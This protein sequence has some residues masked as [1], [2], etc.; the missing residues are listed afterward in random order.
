M[1]KLYRSKPHIPQQDKK[2][3]LSEWKDILDTG[4]FAQG[5]NVENFEKLVAEYCNVKHA[6]ATSSGGTAVEVALMATGIKNK[7]FIVCTQTFVVSISAIIR[8]GN[9]PV[10]VDMDEKS[11]GLSANIIAKHIDS[12]TAGVMLV[13]MAGHITSDY[14]EIQHLCRENNLLLVEDAA[15]AVGASIDGNKAGSIFDVGT[16]SFFPTKIVTTGEGGVIT[17]ND[18]EIAEQA[19]IIRNYGC[20]D[21]RANCTHISNNFK[22]QELSAVLGITQIR[23][24]DEFISKRNVLADRYYTNL[25]SLKS[26]ICPNDYVLE[27]QIHSWWHYMI[28]V[29]KTFNRTELAEALL[30]KG[31]P[32]AT[33]YKPACHEQPIFKEYLIDEYPVADDILNRHLALP[34]HVEMTLDEVDFVCDAIKGFLT[35]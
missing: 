21:Y 10:I 6:I 25:K 17:T 2:F 4:M 23:R 18:D 27:S 22:M 24:I 3:I 1:R 13:H 7:K 34:L 20:K 12:D 19:R 8:S 5:K 14:K 32:T 35:K 33:A 31:I 26:L 28:V 15:H 30:E 29:S 9:I 16:F 11:Q